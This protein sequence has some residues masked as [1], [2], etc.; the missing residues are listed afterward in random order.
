MNSKNKFLG[1]LHLNGH[2]L[3]LVVDL[4]GVGGAEEEDGGAEEEAHGRP[5]QPVAPP[6]PEEGGERDADDE[7]DG[8]EHHG[9]QDQ[10]GSYNENDRG[11]LVKVPPF[12][13]EIR[14]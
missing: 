9:E 14:K 4:L 2:P 13:F 1:P 7:P 12:P 5:R 3:P 8:Q 6:E 11:N 10:D